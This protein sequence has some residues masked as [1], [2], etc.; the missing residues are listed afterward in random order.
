MNRLF[1]LS[2]AHGVGKGYFLSKCV[3]KYKDIVVLEASTLIK[4]KKVADDAGYKRVMNVDDNQSILCEE[5]QMECLKYKKDSTI[6]LDGHLC[7][8][9]SAS[10]IK[11]IPLD[12]CKKANI[13]GIVL[14]QDLGKNIVPRLQQRDGENLTDELIDG[15]QRHEVNFACKMKSLYNIPFEVIS[16]DCKPEKFYSLLMK[17]RKIG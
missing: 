2:G 17:W 9:D 3:E 13:C 16:P 10:N 15:I 14:I 7:M 11:S 12:F 8:L 1:M 5:L 4:R 6:I